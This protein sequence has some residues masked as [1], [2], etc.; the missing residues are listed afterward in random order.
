MEVWGCYFPHVDIFPP[1]FIHD[2]LVHPDIYHTVEL[3]SSM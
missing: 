3:A 1:N 2:M